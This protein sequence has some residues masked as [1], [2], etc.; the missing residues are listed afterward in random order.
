MCS[1]F[2]IL[3]PQTESHSHGVPAFYRTQLISAT[4][5]T[6]F[7]L[8]HLTRQYVHHHLQSIRRLLGRIIVSAPTSG[9]VP[10]PSIDII[11]HPRP[12]ALTFKGP[13]QLG[14]LGSV[15]KVMGWK[16][17]RA[18][19]FPKLLRPTPMTGFLKVRRRRYPGPSENAREAMPRH[20]PVQ[21]RQTHAESP[22]AAGALR[23]AGRS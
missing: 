21:P 12:S 5:K 1:N 3:S 18:R 14:V 19:S 13:L 7:H 16:I 2:F 6:G 20:P 15:F 11:K 9:W 17:A 23:A 8:F 22:A 10:Q 4:C